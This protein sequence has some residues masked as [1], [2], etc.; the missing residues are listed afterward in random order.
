[1]HEHLHPLILAQVDGGLLIHRLRLILLQVVDNHLQ[2]LLVTLHQLGLPWVRHTTDTW[3]QHVVHRLLVVVLLNVHSIHDNR[4]RLSTTRA[5]TLLINAPLTSYKVETTQT[6]YDG[7]LETRHEH[8]HETDAGEVADAAFLVLI[9]HKGHTELEPVHS[10]SITIA[11]FHTAGTHIGDEA[12]F[13]GCTV[14]VGFEN[15]ITDAHLVPEVVFKL[16]QREVLI[17]IL[18]IWTVLIAGVIRLRLVVSVRRVTLRIVDTLITVEDTLLLFIEIGASEI[19]IVIACRVTTPCL[20][21][22]VLRHY[23]TV[24]NL[25]EPLL[26]G[27]VVSL[28]IIVQTVKTHILQFP[29]P[30]GGGKGGGLSG[31]HRNL[32]PLGGGERVGAIHRHAALIELLTISQDILTDLTEVEIEVTRILR[33]RTVLTSVDEGIEQPELDI[34]D[35]GLFEVVDIELAHHTTPLRLR[36]TQRTVFIHVMR[37]VIRAALLRIVGEV[38]DG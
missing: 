20:D 32:T 34:F 27:T 2:C 14:T 1:M 9:L 11:Q 30:F 4:S 10:R 26:I 23:P 29:R 17:D 31:L 6:K 38:Q 35:V 24:D 5:K 19:V 7:F 16:V 21:D 15:L 33:G 28:F 36:L 22:T 37:Q 8:T 3:W 13:W 25:I 12:V 18:H